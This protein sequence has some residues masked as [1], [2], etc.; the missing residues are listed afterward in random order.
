MGIKLIYLL[1]G[2]AAAPVLLPAQ[3]CCEKCSPFP[4]SCTSMQGSHFL[5]YIY[6][7]LSY[8]ESRLEKHQSTL[9]I[10]I[11]K[12]YVRRAY[13]A[14]SSMY[15]RSRGWESHRLSPPYYL[16]VCCSNR[17]P[18]RWWC[19]FNYFALCSL[20]SSQ[21]AQNNCG[22]SC[23]RVLQ[24]LE[25]HLQVI[26]CSIPIFLLVEINV[27]DTYV[28]NSYNCLD[29]NAGDRRK[30][31]FLQAGGSILGGDLFSRNFS[32][33]QA[34][35]QPWSGSVITSFWD[36]QSSP[37]LMWDNLITHALYQQHPLPFFFSSC[38]IFILLC[39]CPVLSR[40]FAT[41]ADSLASLFFCLYSALFLLK[42]LATS[43]NAAAQLLAV[44]LSWS[45][46]PRRSSKPHH[47]FDGVSPFGWEI[48]GGEIAF[49]VWSLSPQALN[50]VVFNLLAYFKNYYSHCSITWSVTSWK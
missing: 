49:L 13:Q 43:R 37:Q 33:L 42:L 31:P 24:L 32:L 21:A 7:A 25:L 4:Y 41:F 47:R 36:F 5:L 40:Y 29:E 28:K 10:K 19:Y 14:C 1:Q 35:L 46:I 8:I 15:Q 27:A 22:K 18:S 50:Q 26:S 11:T 34:A 20:G 6:L 2:T 44:W 16:S 39:S 12:N 3:K 17:L 23:F 30:G 38:N 45:K 48:E 9:I